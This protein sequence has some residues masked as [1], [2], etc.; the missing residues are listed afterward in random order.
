MEKYRR[1]SES[2]AGCTRVTDRRWLNGKSLS[3]QA[4]AALQGGATFLQLRE[5]NASPEQMLEE[6]EKLRK[7]CSRYG[8]PFVIDDDVET[9]L[10]AKADGVHLGQKDMEIAKARELLGPD[11]IIGMSARDSGAGPGGPGKRRRLP[12]SR[13]RSSERPQKMT[14][15]LCHMRRCGRSAASVSIP[16]GGD[17]WYRRREYFT[18]ERN[19]DRR[20]GGGFTR[21]LRQRI[22]RRRSGTDGR[23]VREGYKKDENG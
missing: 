19:R 10:L 8:V 1:A 17:R 22:V 12:G 20:R 13:S 5:K 15:E 23:S 18:V 3:G 4:E 7:L 11:R 21:C 6:A 9:A 14:P 16:G 2:H